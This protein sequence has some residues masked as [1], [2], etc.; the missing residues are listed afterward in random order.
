MIRGLAALAVLSGHLR[1]L[2]FA[3][4]GSLTHSNWLLSV[5]YFTTGLGHEAVMI[6]FVLSGFFVAGSI[7]NSAPRWSWKKYLCDRMVRLYLVLLP[8]LAITALLDRISMRMP[9]GERYFLQSI[10]HFDNQEPIAQTISF[11]IFLGNI[12]FLQQVTVPTFGSNWPLWSLSNEFWYYLLFPLIAISC[13]PCRMATRIAY[14]AAAATIAACLPGAI[15]L[16]FPVWLLGAALH[17]IPR[18]ALGAAGSMLVKTISFAAILALIVLGR[19]DRLPATSADYGLGL[20]FV[21]WIYFLRGATGQ[22]PASPAPSMSRFLARYSRCSAVLAGCSYSIYAI[23]QPI[24]IFLRTVVTAPLWEPSSVNLLA[25]MLA[26][27]GIAGIGYLFS[28]LTEANTE[29]VRRALFSWLGGVPNRDLSA[30]GA[31]NC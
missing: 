27:T 13:Y 3:G 31:A 10:P 28:R 16:Y 4:F 15:L 7:V 11:T 17:F 2:F 12:F 21:I 18:P 14:L 20:A 19:L 24:L 30:R 26:G 22:A 29:R 1:G 25:A 8:A 6:F 23:H 9:L 5:V